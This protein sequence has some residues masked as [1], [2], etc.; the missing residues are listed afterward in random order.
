MNSFMQINSINSMKYKY[1]KVYLF[2]LKGDTE[3]MFKLTDCKFL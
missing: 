1:Y 2:P 3:V